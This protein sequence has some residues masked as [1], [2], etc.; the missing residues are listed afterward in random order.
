MDFSGVIGSGVSSEAAVGG[1]LFL[2]SSPLLSDVEISSKR[3]PFGSVLPKH[4]RSVK[5]ARTEALAEAPGKAA[6]FLLKPNSCPLFPEGEQM[7]SFTSRSQI[8]M[9]VG[10]DRTL[11]YY[12]QPSATSSARCYI[13][14]NAGLTSNL[15]M[16]SVMARARGP[17]T[18]SQWLELE[19]QALIYKYLLANVP[20][21]ATLLVPLR[22]NTTSGFPLSAGAFG[23]GGWGSLHLSYSRNADLEPGRCRRTD[24]K[25]W[26]CS[27]NA[28]ADQKYCERHMNRG[29][30]RSRKHV[31]GQSCRDAKVTPIVTSSHQT[32]AVSVGTCSTLTVTQQQSKAL[33]ATI[34]HPVQP[35]GILNG[36]EV[37]D[38]HAL[39]PQSISI[40]SPVEQRPDSNLYTLSKQHTLLE[41]TSFDAAFDLVSDGSLSNTPRSSFSE[42]NNFTPISMLNDQHLESNPLW[43]CGDDKLALSA[44]KW[45]REYNPA[46][47]GLGVGDLND[48][49]RRQANWRPISWEASLAGPLGEV[50]DRTNCNWKDQSKNFPT[51]HITAN[52]LDSSTRM[53]FSPTGVLQKTS[54]ASLSSSPGSSPMADN[55]MLHEGTSSLCSDLLAST[56]LT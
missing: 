50:L 49:C 43:H 45:S 44:L 27:R 56:L 47:L 30:H 37:Q 31:E 16:Q 40:P 22:R 38:D 25:K 18:P 48:V 32:S 33:Q 41:G 39:N 8:E 28:V 7:L 23:S 55:R 36:K 9:V 1:I 6:P 20:I 12:K 42:N 54:F 52:D 10:G 2:S 53:E 5:A 14:G 21:P 46:Q 51:L 34:A 3:G 4:E 15:N 13:P 24:G 17:F 11:P 26:R 19:H 29:R 35:N